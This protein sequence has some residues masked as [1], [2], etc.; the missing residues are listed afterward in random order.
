[1]GGIRAVTHLEI[2]E[3]C[4]RE[5]LVKL[6]DGRKA[7]VVG[8]D[9]SERC[10]GGIPELPGDDARAHVYVLKGGPYTWERYCDLSLDRVASM[11]TVVTAP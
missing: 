2:V 7:I 6:P 9:T 8:W 5:R 10:A 1:M 4:A 3:A 11:D